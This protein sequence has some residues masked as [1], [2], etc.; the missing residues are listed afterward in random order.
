MKKQL[1]RLPTHCSLSRSYG[2]SLKRVRMLLTC[3]V[4]ALSCSLVARAQTSTFTYQGRLTDGSTVASGTYDLQFSLFDAVRSGTQIGATIEPSNVTVSNGVFTVQLDF[5]S[6][7]FTSGADRFLQIAIKRPGET[8]YTT[9]TPR[10]PLTATPYAIRTLSAAIAETAATAETA[11]TAATATNAQQLGGVAANQYVLTGDARLSD[12]RQPAAGS[13][14]Y[15]QNTT[16][17]QESANFNISGDGTVGGTL[18]GDIVNATNHYNLGGT[19][20]LS[21]DGTSNL[22]VG[23]DTGVI[24]TSSGFNTF[25]GTRAGR[26]NTTGFGNTFVGNGAG[27]F[28]STGGTNSF[29]G[30]DSGKG[31]TTGFNNTIIGHDADVGA[32]N[33][34]NAT[35]IGAGAVVSTSNTVVLG[36]SADTV[37]VPGNLVLIGTGVASGNGLGW[38]NLNATNIATGTLGDAR[39]SSN[40]ARRDTAQTFV[41]NQ[42]VTGNLTV[43]GNVAQTGTSLTFNSANGLVVTGAF[44]SGAIP[45]TGAGVRL[46]WYPN[47]GAFRAGEVNG[48]QWNDANVGINSTALGR[49]ITAS[50]AYSTALGLDTHA[51]GETSTAL[52]VGTNATAVTSTA[53][54]FVTKAS[55][56]NSTAMGNHTTA[57]GSSSTAMGNNT[58]ASGTS[59]MAM[60]DG[61]TASGE[62]STAMGTAASTNEQDGSFVY[63]DSSTGTRI[64]A[65]APNQFV[66]RAQNIWLG[67]N[68]STTDTSGR[69]IETST[70]AFLSTGGAWTNS[71]SRAL[72]TNFAAVNVRDVLR[73]VVQLPLTTWN[74]KAEDAGIRHLGPIAQDFYQTFKLGA[75]DEHIGTID[76]AGVALAAI[77]GLHAELTDRDQR[78]AAQQE[79]IQKQQ[80]QIERQ[81]ILI[82]GLRKL[83]CQQ[84]PQAE[85]CKEN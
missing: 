66:V 16:S 67:K 62:H 59:S 53:M 34:S 11:T 28:N 10:Q 50:G 15:V 9:L 74:Y 48:I 38:N 40:V 65:S 72:K 71:S 27:P 24:F 47:K 35:A 77:Q 29:F 83:A 17:P 73:G 57:S 52:G 85:V 26:N 39:L 63:G 1:Q 14:N 8:A 55:G 6:S 79:Q 76:S 22:F 25:I 36:R 61:T 7:P 51:S 4:V 56:P 81:Q 23:T 78:M 5:G 68:N 82:N 12:V 46:M 43:N 58:T 20:V 18:S 45:A 3:L 33:L 49:D 30:R 80:T 70:G 2:R 69:F 13:P 60:G 31:N 44:G 32:G 19:R 41:G 21:I 42:T 84:N 64:N 75:D 37:R 54:G